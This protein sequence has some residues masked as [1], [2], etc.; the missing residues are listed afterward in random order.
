MIKLCASYGLKV[1]ASQ[2]YSSES[3]HA[4]AEVE[5]AGNLQGEALKAA[6]GNLWSDL[7][8]AVAEQ[9]SAT[10]KP[11]AGNNGHEPTPQKQ[12]ERQ[13][14]QAPRRVEP[15]NRVAGNAEGASKKQIGFLLALARRKRNQSA[16]QVRNWLQAER[17]QNLNGLSKA[18]AAALIDEF[19]TSN[20]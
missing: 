7:K 12:P 5:V 14:E 3:F 1:P 13:V 10:V 15:V 8:V 18:E 6:L 11:S 16:E 20:N 4:S 2:E 19:N 9:R 17:N